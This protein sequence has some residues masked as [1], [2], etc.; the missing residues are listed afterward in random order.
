MPSKTALQIPKP[1]TL[2]SKWLPAEHW[3]MKTEP[4]V[5]SFDDLLKKG[6]EKWDGV[7]NYQARNFMRDEMKIGHKLIIYHSNANP[8]G[9]AGVAEVVKLAEED[10]TALDKRSD[11]H[12]P[13]AMVGQNPWCCVTVG[14]PKVRC[15]FVSLDV[16]KSD[17]ELKQMLLVRKGQ[18]LSILPLK[19]AEF[20]RIT[21][22]MNAPKET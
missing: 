11:Y 3:L 10:L 13:K 14:L 2:V 19:P 5:F 7:R 17:P 18:R 1:P 8:P 15:R 6:S 9:A 21:E 20:R 16:L 22:L 12:D 4:D